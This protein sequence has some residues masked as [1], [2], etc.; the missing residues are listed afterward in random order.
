MFRNR[1]VTYNKALRW[2]KE[3]FFYTFHVRFT[4]ITLSQLSPIS[5]L[6]SAFHSNSIPQDATERVSRSSE[7]AVRNNNSSIS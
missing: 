1:I 6:L 7:D 3:D 4:S 2:K 5:L